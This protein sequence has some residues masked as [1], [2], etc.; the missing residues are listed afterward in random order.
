MW[1]EGTQIVPA[2]PY[3]IEGYTYQSYYPKVN[4]STMWHE[5]TQIEP[6]VPYTIEGYTYQS[7]YPKVNY[8]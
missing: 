7:Y 2:V 1:H 8:K 4:Y 5:E 3:P 6:A